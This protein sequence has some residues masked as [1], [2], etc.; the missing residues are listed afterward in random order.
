MKFGINNVKLVNIPLVSYS[1][2]S[3]ILCPCSREE[4]D[5]MSHVPYDSVVGSLM[6]AMV[7]TRP[8]I[9]YVVGVI[10][11]YMANPSK[12]HWETMKWVLHYL[13]G[14]SAYC[15]TYNGCSDYV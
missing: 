11:R 2:L 15:I 14:I 7:S 6:Y 5:D 10:S 13:K 8:Y 4:K 3:S 1:K 9:S 12:E